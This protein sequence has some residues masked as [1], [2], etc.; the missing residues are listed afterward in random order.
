MR[1]IYVHIP[2]CARRCSYCDFSIAVRKTIPTGRY[3]TAIRTELEYRRQQNLWDELSTDTLYFGGG[4]PSL[5]PSEGIAALVDML[6]AGRDGGAAREVTLEA[7]PDDVTQTSANAWFA[8]GIT[9]VSLGG[10][11]F[12]PSVLAWMHR[13][14]DV[15]AV[16][17]AVDR[18][19]T[20]GIRDVS[21]DLIFG[22]PEELGS[23]IRYDLDC[24]LQLEPDHLSVY[25]LSVESRTPLAKW[26]ASGRTSAPSDERYAREF[27][28]VHDVL[29]AAGYEHYEVSNYGRPGHHSRHNSMYWTEAAFTGLGPAAHS[30]R[31]GERSWNHANWSAYEHAVLSGEG[32]TADYEILT[33]S[34]RAIERIYLGLRTSNGVDRSLWRMPQRL[35]DRAWREQAWVVEHGER[36][37]LTPSGWLRLDE[38]V[39]ALTT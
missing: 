19:R 15:T 29:S 20:A 34:Q 14:H 26:I 11:S 10:Q 16:G 38:I 24:A 21:L 37:R 17:L 18:L 2:F 5:L 13:T 28:L 7:N 30:F 35:L 23:D 3:L 9:R 32:P 27:L 1:H 33:E 4:T 22:L 25:G 8:A 39:A 31:D 12:A 36:L 6:G